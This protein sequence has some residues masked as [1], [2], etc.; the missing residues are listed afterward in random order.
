MMPKLI[1]WKSFFVGSQKLRRNKVEV[2]HIS[3][4]SD[5]D[6]GLPVIG[7]E[8][9]ALGGVKFAFPKFL[10]DTRNLDGFNLGELVHGIA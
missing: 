4:I 9:L 10:N 2:V 8:Q 1:K 5:G 3:R 7:S 6:D